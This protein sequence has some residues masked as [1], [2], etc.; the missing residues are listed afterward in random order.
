[1]RN[2]EEKQGNIGLGPR[3]IF[4]KEI[5][6]EIGIRKIGYGFLKYYG[7]VEIDL[8]RK[9]LNCSE[10]NASVADLPI[11]VLFRLTIFMVVGDLCINL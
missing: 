7:V 10:I 4:E 1:L 2:E 3:I 9:F 5:S 6:C 11:I 8:G